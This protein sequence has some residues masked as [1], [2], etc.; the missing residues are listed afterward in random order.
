MKNCDFALNYLDFVVN[1]YCFYLCLL[2]M[3]ELVFTVMLKRKYFFLL[4]DFFCDHYF[5]FRQVRL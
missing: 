5:F 1:G 3:M 4:T 2:S